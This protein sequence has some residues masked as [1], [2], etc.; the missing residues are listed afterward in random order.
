MIKQIRARDYENDVDRAIKYEPVKKCPL[1]DT[2]F[3]G[4]ALSHFLVPYRDPFLRTRTAAPCLY[5][6]HFCASC[7]MCFLG[8]Y[9]PERDDYDRVFSL[10]TAIPSASKKREFQNQIV[11]LSP[12]FVKVYNE[13]ASAESHRLN[14]VCGFGYR[15]AL[16]FL[17]KDFAAFLYPDE[18][19]KIQDMPLSQCINKYIEHQKLKIAATRAVWLGN[20]HAHY[21]AKHTDKDLNDL[22]LLVDL[23]VHWVTMELE[24]LEAEAIE[25][26]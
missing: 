23:S 7:E 15:R 4:D 2:S 25:K 14:E 10:V 26:K 3:N 9:T 18:S 11:K 5:S 1:C 22:K 6:L 17:I 20:D 21:L 12:M 16:E 24:T 13:A 8:V 19:T